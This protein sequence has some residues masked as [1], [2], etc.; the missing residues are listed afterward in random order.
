MSFAC[1]ITIPK[2]TKTSQVLWR[3][4]HSQTLPPKSFPFFQNSSLLN[5]FLPFSLASVDCRT[6]LRRVRGTD[7]LCEIRSQCLR[8]WHFFH[9]SISSTKWCV[10]DVVTISYN[11]LLSD[12]FMS[13]LSSPRHC[14][15]PE[16]M[17]WI[18][19]DAEGRGFT[20]IPSIPSL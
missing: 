16:Q 15:E 4:S 5:Q 13:P 2:N 1:F 17:Y 20:S 18:G 14:V 12:H 6:H 10:N 7:P 8:R 3:S 11:S 19:G 9:F